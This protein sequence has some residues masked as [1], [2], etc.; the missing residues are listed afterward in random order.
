MCFTRDLPERGRIA[1]FIR[2][3]Y[4]EVLIVHVHSEILQ[5]RLPDALLDGKAV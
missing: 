1:I 4:Q 3:Y 5:R 2:S